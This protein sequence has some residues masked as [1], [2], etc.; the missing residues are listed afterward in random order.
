M[1]ILRPESPFMQFLTK[2][3][4]LMWINL[5]TLVC[6]IPVFTAGAAFTAM[7]YVLLQIVRDSE[8]SVTKSFFASFRSNFRQAT[9]IWLGVLAAAGLFVTGYIS[10]KNLPQ[11]QEEVYRVVLGV[12]GIL[13]VSVVLYVFPLLSHFDNPVKR[14]VLNAVVLMLT[15][16]LRTAEM[17]VIWGGIYYFA[18]KVLMRIL[19]VFFVFCFTLPGLLSMLVLNPIF[20]SFEKDDGEETHETA[21][22]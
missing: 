8:G 15:H 19:P 2:M 6:C 12:V 1:G 4:H 18:F 17:L 3:T 22:V 11:G 13:A 9:L 21:A 7:N 10:A 16:P 20:R 14:T 5:L